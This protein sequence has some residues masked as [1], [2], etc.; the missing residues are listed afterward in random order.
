MIGPER[1]PLQDK[2]GITGIAD[3]DVCSGWDLGDGTALYLARV[4]T[5]SVLYV[6]VNEALLFGQGV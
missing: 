4:R 3:V 5:S 6:Y 2:P 1:F